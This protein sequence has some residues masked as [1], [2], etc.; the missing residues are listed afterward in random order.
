MRIDSLYA[1]GRI[2]YSFEI[3]PPKQDSPID[4]IYK[5]LDGLE[6]LAP[7][8]IS[9]TY[10]AGGTP[11]DKSTIEISG[12]I[13]H[14]Y[15]IEPLAHLTC[16]NSVRS[17][18]DDILLELRDKDVENILALRGDR[19]AG[20][21]QKND[22]RFAYQLMDYIG[23]NAD[24][25]LAGACYPETHPDSESPDA[26]I[27]ALLQKQQSGAKLLISQL[28]FDNELFYSFV[29]RARAAGVT[30]PI[31]AGIMPVVNA[32]QIERMVTQCGASLPGK[33]VKVMQR[34]E[35]RPKAMRDAGIAYAVDQIVDLAAHGVDGIHLYTMNSPYV[36]RKIT[37]SI[38]NIIR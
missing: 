4:T 28:F 17:E 31:E 29:E 33:F 24:F 19:R 22:F 35:S 25:C 26:D 7:D 5:T 11:S 3:F 34:Y 21:E 10:G 8:Y 2:V 6:G 32:R 30:L 20:V 18:I 1:Q 38:S 13:K 14:K 12:L 23:E 37:S 9:V 36:A 15:G 27:A 16:L